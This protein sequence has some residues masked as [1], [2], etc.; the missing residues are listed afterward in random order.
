MAIPI[1][2]DLS[3]GAGGM[4]SPFSYDPHTGET[5]TFSW[6]EQ[7]RELSAVQQQQQPMDD[8][9][10]IGLDLSTQVSWAKILT[11]LHSISSQ[12]GSSADPCFGD[13]VP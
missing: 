3:G 5:R 2:N 1:I 7:Q 11:R 12:A 6:Q 8:S 13:V 4:P 10:F 9:L